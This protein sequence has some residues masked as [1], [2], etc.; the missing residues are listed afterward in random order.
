MSLMQTSHKKVNSL[1]TEHT[2]L[3]SNLKSGF[4]PSIKPPSF[5]HLEEIDFLNDDEDFREEAFSKKKKH[6][7]G[8]HEKN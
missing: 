5:K 2:S 8:I 6:H 1:P 3:L 4:L 7:Q